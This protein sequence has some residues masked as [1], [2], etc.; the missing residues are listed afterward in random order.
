MPEVWIPPAA[1][2]LTGGQQRVQVLGS[3]VRQVVDNL[4]K[5][6]PGMKARL[7]E[8]DEIMP[9]MAVIVDGEVSNIGMMHRVEEGSEIHFLPAI[10]GGM[11][12]GCSRG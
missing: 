8:E 5:A 12:S 7:C 6:Y 2:E 1:Q 10:G 11:A 4:D 9:G 3:T